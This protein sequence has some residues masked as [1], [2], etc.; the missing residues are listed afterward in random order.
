[1]SPASR[2]A[3]AELPRR[4]PSLLAWALLCGLVALHGLGLGRQSLWLDEAATWREAGSPRA[5]WTTDSAGTERY[6]KGY[7]WLVAV[8]KQAFGETPA[9][10]RGP[11]VLAFCVAMAAGMLLW[12]RRG[13]RGAALAFGL[14]LGLS[15]YWWQYSQEARPY[16]LGLAAAMLIFLLEDLR[17]GTCVPVRRAIAL[18]AALVLVLALGTVGNLYVILVWPP[19]LLMDLLRARKIGLGRLAGVHLGL[20][21]AMGLLVAVGIIPHGGRPMCVPPPR[22]TSPGEFAGLVHMLLLGPSWGPT[23]AEL[24]T[25]AS[26]LAA[27][28][29]YGPW[30]LVSGAAI[31]LAAW[32]FVSTRAWRE[33]IP[34]MLLGSGVLAA[35]A[36]LCW[37]EG[38][39]IAPRHL[40]LA[41]PVLVGWLAVVLRRRPAL[42]LPL[43]ACMVVA[44]LNYLFVPRY[45]R[46]DWR[47]VLGFISRQATE[48][49]TLVFYTNSSPSIF[50]YYIG[51]PGHRRPGLTLVRV[52]E[53]EDSMGTPDYLVEARAWELLDPSAR[54][55]LGRLKREM[56]PLLTTTGI[57]LWRKAGGKRGG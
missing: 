38:Y 25:A 35:L 31:A 4:F 45:G 26:P 12:R 15:P 7:L 6:M 53:A 44:S 55:R 20:L 9:V 54:D 47:E 16:A 30:F 14:V 32:G 3:Q 23:V 5:V 48:G 41:T 49:K 51:R 28:R 8:T 52:N 1:M 18:D 22:I 46:E 50:D 42:A 21:C 24:R 57:T 40:F 27:V 10:L 39:A 37:R 34:E 13:G 2:P 29:A 56:E 17:H 43:L 19:L 11:S 36:Y 33:A